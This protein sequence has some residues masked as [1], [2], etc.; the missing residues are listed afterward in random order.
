MGEGFVLL[1]SGDVEVSLAAEGSG[2]RSGAGPAAAA[3]P[4]TDGPADTS[5]SV[6]LSGPTCR[7]RFRRGLDRGWRLST[8]D[9]LEERSRVASACMHPEHALRSDPGLRDSR[10]PPLL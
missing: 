5:S 8:D 9:S 4:G 2:V 3:Q 10:L 6:V 1:L 7:C